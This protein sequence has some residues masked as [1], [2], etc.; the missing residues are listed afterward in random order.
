MSFCRG[1]VVVS[2]L[3]LC[4]IEVVEVV[5]VWCIGDEIETIGI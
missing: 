2:F 1:G 4:I 3:L 5:L